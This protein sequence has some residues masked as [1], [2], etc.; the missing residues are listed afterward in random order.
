MPRKLLENVCYEKG[1]RQLFYVPN[2][3]TRNCIDI[4]ATSIPQKL[5]ALAAN[6]KKFESELEDVEY[7]KSEIVDII[8]YWRAIAGFPSGPIAKWMGPIIPNDVEIEEIRKRHGD[9]IKSLQVKPVEEHKHKS[10]EEHKHKHEHK[11]EHKHKDKEPVSAVAKHAPA[12]QQSA[13]AAEAWFSASDRVEKKRKKPTQDDFVEEDVQQPKPAKIRRVS[14]NAAKSKPTPVRGQRLALALCKSTV[15]KQRQKIRDLE[16]KLKSREFITGKDKSTVGVLP[17]QVRRA[18]E[19]IEE[20]HR[21]QDQKVPRA[22]ATEEELLAIERQMLK[23]EGEFSKYYAYD[24]PKL[25]CRKFV[26]LLGSGI[27]AEAGIPTFRGFGH[28]T[29]YANP[30]VLKAQLSW[31]EH[32][33]DKTSSDQVMF[34]PIDVSEKFPK[35]FPG[36]Q[37]LWFSLFN[38][39]EAVLSEWTRDN[40][41]LVLTDIWKFWLDIIA[42]KKPTPFHMAI[43][44][45]CRRGQCSKVVTMNIDGF[46]FAA[47]VPENIMI[48]S[49]GCVFVGSR[50]RDYVGVRSSKDITRDMRMEVV[51]YDEDILMDDADE[52]SIRHALEDE[53]A[54]LV[55]AGLSMASIP[56]WLHKKK[57]KNLIVV[58][59]NPSAIMRAEQ[60]IKAQKRGTL[61]TA[62]RTTK[63]FIAHY[64]PG[65]NAGPINIFNDDARSVENAVFNFDMNQK[66]IERLP[67]NVEPKEVIIISD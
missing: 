23:K 20:R 51:M 36:D 17:P 52:S 54:C 58:N 60:F 65:W 41:P 30:L 67:E 12:P 5:F 59:P 49:H 45:L 34:P 11:H 64:L 19:A 6:P 63:D 40:M 32:Y 38:T 27:S 29:K 48:P 16:I 53:G 46:E 56:V 61:V 33:M 57:V 24:A 13:A 10:V 39:I 2:P 66:I 14:Y 31:R 25:G 28:D 43:A 9:F 21:M 8:N 26:F 55:V 35:D 18:T 3:L 4:K 47:G 44:E 1:Q 42:H 15:E 62:F 22:P 7:S 37:E 50:G